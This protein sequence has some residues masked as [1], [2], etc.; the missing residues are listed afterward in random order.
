[1]RRRKALRLAELPNRIAMPST[2]S[3]LERNA[4]MRAWRRK[5]QATWRPYATEA[6]RKHRAKKKPH[7]A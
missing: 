2:L 7:Q 3:R 1:M 5:N 4:Y 6:M